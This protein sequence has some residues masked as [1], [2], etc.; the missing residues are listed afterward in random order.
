MRN[1]IKELSKESE[2]KKIPWFPKAFIY[3]FFLVHM[4]AFWYSWFSISYSE[5][6]RLFLF[7]FIHWW[8]AIFVYMIFYLAI[9]WLDKIKDM[10][11]WALIGIMWTIARLEKIIPYRWHEIW[12]YYRAAHII[13]GLY[14]VMYTFLIKQALIDIISIFHKK[15]AKKIAEIIY[16]WIGISVLGVIFF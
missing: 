4:A 9:F 2:K 8:F 12:D 1:L 5:P 11:I 3:P 10:L 7:G 16:I 13:P 6:G 14:F 15:H